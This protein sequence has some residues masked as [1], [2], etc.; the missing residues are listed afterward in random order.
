MSRPDS[1][2]KALSPADVP[3]DANAETIAKKLKPVPLE[4]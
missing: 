2:A 1:K 3:A 4:S